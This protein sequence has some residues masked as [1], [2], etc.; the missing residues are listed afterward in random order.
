[1]QQGLLPGSIGML[2]FGCTLL[3]GGL[4]LFITLALRAEKRARADQ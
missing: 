2:V 1:M 3:Y 4:A